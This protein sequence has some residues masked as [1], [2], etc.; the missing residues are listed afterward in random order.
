VDYWHPKTG[1]AYQATL[2]LDFIG[3]DPATLKS[4]SE[5]GT[6]PENSSVAY[7]CLFQQQYVTQVLPP[8]GPL[9]VPA[10]AHQSI[11]L[12]TTD[13]RSC[14]ADLDLVAT[15][16]GQLSYT[17]SVP[18]ATCNIAGFLGGSAVLWAQTFA[19]AD[20]REPGPP[21]AT[22][23]FQCWYCAETSSSSGVLPAVHPYTV[24]YYVAF[25]IGD[26]SLTALPPGCTP[27]ELTWVYCELN[28]SVT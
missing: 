23:N 26:S 17:G 4:T 3:L 18:P 19:Y 13:G 14:D 15:G 9:P 10:P 2:Q 16:P 20:R 27:G 12:A 1:H 6:Q 21:V 22:G 25:D 24:T 8:V 5:C 11:T 28:A 7:V